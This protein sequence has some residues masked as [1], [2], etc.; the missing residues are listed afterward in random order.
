M[1]ITQ[2]VDP[3]GPA[4]GL[5]WAEDRC[6][7]LPPMEWQE[8]KAG[9]G[10]PGECKW[11]AMQNA[12]VLKCKPMEHGVFKHVSY[13]S[14]NHAQC[15]ICGNR[16]ECR[17]WMSNENVLSALPSFPPFLFPLLPVFM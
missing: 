6:I 7:H 5:L 14:A 12:S 1:K 17:D 3:V 2:Q 10:P 8:G 9:I 15:Y 4:K 13:P 11:A 16:R